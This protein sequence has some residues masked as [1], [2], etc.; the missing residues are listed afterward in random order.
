MEY[1]IKFK[2]TLTENYVVKCYLISGTD[3]LEQAINF[4]KLNSAG[5]L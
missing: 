1:Q 5:V 4:N 2:N 3:A